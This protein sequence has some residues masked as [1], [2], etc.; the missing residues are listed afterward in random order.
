MYV[1]GISGD[2]TGTLDASYYKGCGMANGLERDV[3]A[4]DL[5]NSNESDTNGALQSC[6]AQNTH[7]NNVVRQGYTPMECERLQGYED[8]W[9]DIGDYKD[10]NGKIQHTA[11]AKRYKALGNS[12][13]LPAWRW[14]IRKL[15]AQYDT[16]PT[17]ASLFDGIGGFPFLW[18]GINGK[19][20]CLWA[21]EIDE[22]CIAVTERRING[23][24]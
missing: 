13:A 21:S 16:Y 14:I 10:S 3:V 5:M 15:S 9:T 2:R 24:I 20:T 6:S 18:E 1:V 8:G 22:F 12:I 23:R 7:G 11:D 4:V 19:G 17:M